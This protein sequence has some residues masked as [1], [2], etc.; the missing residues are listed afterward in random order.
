[1]CMKVK[2]I[3]K[4]GHSILEIALLRV[5]RIHL[6]SNTENRII[7]LSSISPEKWCME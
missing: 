4:I 6:H 7:L 1:M 2:V 5:E 3:N